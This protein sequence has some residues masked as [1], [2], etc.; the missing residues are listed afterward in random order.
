MRLDPTKEQL[1]DSPLQIEILEWQELAKTLV[2]S[3]RVRLVFSR[4]ERINSPDM[5]QVGVLQIGR[6]GLGAAGGAGAGCR[7]HGFAVE[8]KSVFFC[9]Q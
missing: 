7:D 3:E 9:D 1:D 8:L 2:E 6:D 4:G 5:V